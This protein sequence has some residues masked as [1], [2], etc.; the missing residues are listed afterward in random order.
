MFKYHHQLLPKAFDNYFQ[1]VSTIHRYNTR[2]ASR[3]SYYAEPIRTNFGRFSF[4]YNRPILW[5][6]IDKK[7]KTLSLHQFKSKLKS[8]M[9]NSYL[10]QSL[11]TSQYYIVIIIIQ[12]IPTR[13]LSSIILR[14]IIPQLMHFLHVYLLT[15]LSVH[16][17]FFFVY[18]ALYMYH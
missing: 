12:S 6:T 4:K 2:L 7:L 17:L 10:D 1:S 15:D 13:S 14:Y 8:K 9:L 3:S 16:H 11:V 5:N 18:V